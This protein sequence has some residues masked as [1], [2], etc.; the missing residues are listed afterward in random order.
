MDTK[1]K[2]KSKL[3]IDD[4]YELQL[5]SKLH[6]ALRWVLMLPIG[7]LAILLVQLAYGFVFNKLLSNFDTSSVFTNGGVAIVIN[8]L[9]MAMKYCVFVVAMVGVAP[10]VRE[11]KFQASIACA[12]IAVVVCLGSTGFLL[13]NNGVENLTMLIATGGSAFLGI[14]WAVL[15][16]RSTVSKPLPT[17]Q[18]GEL[19]ELQTRKNA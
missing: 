17:E 5:V 1:K 19:A 9:F 7:L 16:V 14:V 4:S 13:Y 18:E 6:P 10:V 11:K 15:N 2:K 8:S 12:I 3:E